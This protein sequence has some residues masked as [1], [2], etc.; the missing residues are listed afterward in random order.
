MSV[1][2]MDGSDK[3]N[4]NVPEDAFRDVVLSGAVRE[5]AHLAQ[6][7]LNV[8]STILLPGTVESNKVVVMRQRHVIFDFSVLCGA[9]VTEWL[10][11]DFDCVHLVVVVVHRFEHLAKRSFSDYLNDSECLFEECAGLVFIETWT[12][13]WCCG[14]WKEKDD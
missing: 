4:D 5:Q 7:R 13:Q 10:N 14:A 1:Q 12:V 3:I 6:L 8:Q 11:G 2:V 9:V